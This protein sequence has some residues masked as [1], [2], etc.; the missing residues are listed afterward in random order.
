MKRGV[1]AVCLAALLLGACS[2]QHPTAVRSRPT[3]P[4]PVATAPPVPDLPV[5]A[6][7]GAGNLSPKVSGERALVYVPNSESATVDVID[8]ATF[9]VVGHFA[10]GRLPQ[11]VTPSWDLGTLYVDNDQGNSLTPIDPHTAEPGQAIPVDDPY[12]LYFSPDGTKAIVVAERRHRLDV[13]DPHT[14]KL[15]ASLPVPCRGVDHA[16][17]T[18]DGTVMVASCEF[19]ADL[20]R[21]DLRTLTVTAALH[22]GG[23]PVDV[24]LSPDG[25]VMYVANQK[26]GGVSVIDPTSLKEVRFIPTGKGTHG[27]YPS[28]DARWLYATNRGEGTISVLDFATGAPHATWRIGG[29]PDMGGVTADGSQLWVSG[30]YDGAVYV[31]DTATGRLLHT[32]KVGAG[33]H[34]LCVWPQP[35]RYSLGHTGNTR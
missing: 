23:Q 34:G 3:G 15:I 10:V 17:F 33:P 25:S 29:S 31:V 20:V 2:G 24:K 26:R 1:R 12:N 16:D 13:R 35:G 14:W 6:H 21:V 11:H 32:I 8:P 22:V 27:L 9:A 30:R 19:S 18:S 4:A 5:Y 7:T 28:R